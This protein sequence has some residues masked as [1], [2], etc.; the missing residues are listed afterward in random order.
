MKILYL[1]IASLVVDFAVVVF[2]YAVASYWVIGASGWEI[3][4]LGRFTLIGF[5]AAMTLLVLYV[6]DIY[7]NYRIFTS[8]F[9]LM[10]LWDALVYV[11]LAQGLLVYFLG[12]A[13]TIGRGIF[14][15]SLVVQSILFSLSKGIFS[16]FVSQL[17]PKEH[18]LIVGYNPWKEF[19]FD[20]LK[21]VGS[22]RLPFDI[23]G[24]VSDNCEGE[25]MRQLPFKV[26]G[27]YEDIE[28]IVK[29]YGVQTL[30]LTSTYAEK[31]SLQEFLIMAH[32]N[33]NRLIS[34]DGLYED[35]TKKVPYNLVNK[36][37]LLNECLLAN[38]FAQLKKKRVFDVVM[39]VV[40]IALF[41]PLACLVAFAIK[42]TSRGSI[43]YV[44]ERVGFRG[45][46]FKMIKF[47][48]MR[49]DAERETGA[50]FA[51]KNDPRMTKF[52]RF[53]RKTRLDE[54]PQLLN[55]LKGDMSIVGPRPEREE[56]IKKL[57]KRISIYALRLFTKP[58][59]TGW[60]QVAH[61]YAST[62]SDLEE[63]FC[64]DLYY[65][66]HMTLSFDVKIVL[67]T[68]THLLLARGQ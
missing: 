50:V 12:S 33:H 13:E 2:S 7:P 27:P 23:V 26:L 38:R 16:L 44:Q 61:G 43:F 42:L 22:H 11:F 65:L 63:K 17:G 46:I 52:G 5:I 31:D 66:K 4:F 21:T 25:F 53:L 14:A 37:E 58:G 18:A 62:I 67:Q 40:L 6:F 56:F 10:I 8:F 41:F 9:G 28:K 24:I 54:L 64:Y 15:I 29:D 55:V 34:L 47:R 35:I 19:Y 59:I 68:I 49:M 36:A 51:E 39:S 20:F 30:I 48:T 57:E 3:Y 45:Q 1:K 60:A 32:Q